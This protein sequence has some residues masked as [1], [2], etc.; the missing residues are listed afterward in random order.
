MKHGNLTFLI[1][2]LFTMLSYSQEEIRPN[3]LWILIE[4]IGP[5]L[6]SYGY[7]GVKTPNI[8]DL[9]S[10]GTLY[11]KAFVNAPVCSPS[12]SSLITAMYP[13][14]IGAHQHRSVHPLPDSI[15]TIPELFRNAGYFT[16]LGNKH[17][18]KTDYNF[19]LNERKLWDGD[20]WSQR[21]KDQP[22][23]AQLTLWNSHRGIHWHDRNDP[24]SWLNKKYKDVISPVSLKDVVMPSVIPDNIFTRDDWAKYLNQ[25]QVIDHTVGEIVQRL[26]NE[27][28]FE[29]TIIVLMAD[30]GRDH[31]RNEYWLYDGG[32]HVPLI[33]AWKDLEAGSVS[34]ELVSGVDIP[35]SLLS[36]C[37]IEI[38][39]YL[40][41]VS[42]LS[43]NI[44]KREYIYASRD[45]IDDAYDMIRC[46][47]DKK[48][49]YIR[50]FMPN[51]PYTQY[52]GWL[53]NVNPSFSLLNYLAQNAPNEL[54]EVQIQ[55]TSD[56]KPVEEL[57]D[58]INDPEEQ[59][60]LAK[61]PS[62]QK[63]IIKYRSLLKNWM[64]SI[65]DKA[66]IRENLE[67][68]IRDNRFKE[69]I[70]FP[71]GNELYDPDRLNEKH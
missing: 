13:N 6:S 31:I 52:R 69:Y 63:E 19:P 25:I 5:E 43:N 38:P 56:T 29:N 42:F 15:L 49:K 20:D 36:A 28:L 21:K 44:E 8:D 9:A 57:Y 48:F 46:V 34:E 33:V 3:V 22:F 60:N 11:K 32:L 61:N 17:S 68:D 4:N 1:V 59:H 24:R 53:T 16:S 10:K 2:L 55:Y 41:G 58:T 71:T 7:P 50:N 35:V 40:H 47:R 39:E 23:F 65:D 66:R 54:N 26:K 64:L 37:E 51:R 12:R 62:Y 30:N 27:G 18:G 14:A 70:K 45:R 67:D